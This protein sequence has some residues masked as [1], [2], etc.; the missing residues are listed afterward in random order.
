MAEYLL[1]FGEKLLIES[2]LFD[3]LSGVL[4][5]FLPQTH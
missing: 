5:I 1:T 3:E 4:E 2:R